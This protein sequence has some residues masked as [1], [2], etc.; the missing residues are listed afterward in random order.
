MAK[1]QF[2]IGKF[3]KGYTPK[4]YGKYGKYGFGSHDHLSA[5]STMAQNRLQPQL[6]VP[7]QEDI[8]ADFYAGLNKKIGDQPSL[9]SGLLA[10]FESHARGKGNQK[11]Q[12]MVEK[13]EKTMGYLQQ[14]NLDAMQRLD[15]QKKE[16]A[17]KAKYLPE[18]LTYVRSTNK[19]DPQ[20]QLATVQ[21]MFKRYAQESGNNIEVL[22]VDSIDPNV[23]TLGVPGNT[24][25]GTTRVDLRDFF[26]DNQQVQQE[27]AMLGPEYQAMLQE[28]RQQMEIANMQADRTADLRQQEIYSANSRNDMNFNK[29][30]FA[31]DPYRQ[32]EVQTGKQQGK[33]AAA[34]LTKLETAND[35]F[36]D[37]SDRVQDLK[38]LLIN[39]DVITGQ[40]LSAKAQRFLGKLT[41]SKAYSDTELYDAINGGLISYIKGQEKYGNLNMSEFSFLLDRLPNSEKTREA[42]LRLL[43]QVERRL[44]RSIERNNRKIA[45]IPNY[46]YPAEQNMNQAPVQEEVIEAAPMASP[47]SNITQEGTAPQANVQQP[48]GEVLVE[49]PPYKNKDG[50]MVKK[51]ISMTPAKAQELVKSG[52]K[53]IQQK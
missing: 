4:K 46:S 16:E 27:L 31:Q 45:R 21:S 15:E 19:L 2:E 26:A 51:V 10:G 49:T 18:V 38:N 52:A 9:A 41:G 30:T 20:S 28:K 34:Q 33:E 48:D 13:Y 6:S 40:T 22:G 29:M 5:A 14:V 42:I 43:D 17:T 1:D 53:I 8:D 35:E 23:I 37:V 11:R 12:D 32:F 36:Y 50:K 44:S 7:Q 24:E 25:A 3:R 39:S 47:A